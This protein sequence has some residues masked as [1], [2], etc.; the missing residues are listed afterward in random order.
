MNNI[1]EM[2]KNFIPNNNTNYKFY[3]GLVLILLI[4]VFL[5]YYIYTKYY[6]PK[7]K[8]LYKPNKEQVPLWN[9]ESK[10]EAELLLFYANWCPHCKS[11]KP[12]WEKV[13]SEYENKLINGYKVIFVEVDCSSPNPNTTKMMDEYNIEGFPTIK[14]NKNNQIITYDAKV[15]QDHLVEF[16]KTAL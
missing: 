10:N 11:A 14:L 12:E 8:E 6:S 13:K 2:T 9:K 1:K 4:L 5:I 15:T 7:L 16:L 3:I